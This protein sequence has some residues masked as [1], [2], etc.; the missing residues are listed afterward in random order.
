MK[1]RW[2]IDNFNENRV[3]IYIYRKILG[4]I[5]MKFKV[6]ILL[7]KKIRWVKKVIINVNLWYYFKG[8]LFYIDR[9]KKVN[10]K[11]E[12]NRLFEMKENVLIMVIFFCLRK[13][14]LLLLLK[15]FKRNLLINLK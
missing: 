8:N 4:I 1:F 7:F 6:L 3:F 11:N 15:V 9:W 10:V 5:L 2:L 13:L 12:F 14:E